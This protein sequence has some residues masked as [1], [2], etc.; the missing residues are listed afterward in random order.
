ML[1]EARLGS[2]LFSHSPSFEETGDISRRNH[3]FL[4]EMTSE[5]QMQKFHPDDVSLPRFWLV[6]L[7]DKFASN[8]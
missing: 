7:R 2:S 6:V 4:R 1:V 8:N 5:E 3:W